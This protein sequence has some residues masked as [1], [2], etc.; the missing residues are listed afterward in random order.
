V[1]NA[2]LAVLALQIFNALEAAF[3]LVL[4]A[5]TA[6]LGKRTRGFT[7]RRQFALVVFLFG[8]GISDII[9]VFTGAW[10]RPLSLLALKAVCLVGLCVTAGMIYFTRWKRPS[11]DVP[12]TP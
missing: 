1:R 5:L 4:A 12:I 10:W 6:A 11:S 7:P 8:F 2:E 3:W 9:E